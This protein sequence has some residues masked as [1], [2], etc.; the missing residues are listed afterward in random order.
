MIFQAFY[1]YFFK[2]QKKKIVYDLQKK[3][4]QQNR[5]HEKRKINQF[6]YIYKYKEEYEEANANKKFRYCFLLNE[7]FC[8]HIFSKFFFFKLKRNN[9][10]KF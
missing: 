4:Q 10:L 7:F 9:I 1:E 8:A 2:T 6:N 5:E 3:Q